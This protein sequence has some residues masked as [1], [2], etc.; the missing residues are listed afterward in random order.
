MLQE[1]FS[2]VLLDILEE[3][4]ETHHGVYLELIGISFS[5]RI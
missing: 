5:G 4:F 2:K 3:T 1:S